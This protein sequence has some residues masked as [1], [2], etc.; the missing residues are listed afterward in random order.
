MRHV[1]EE[2]QAGGAGG[3]TP[4]EIAATPLGHALG[5]AGSQALAARLRR[6]TLDAGAVLF[7]QGDAGEQL[8]LVLAGR[9]LAT[10][11]GEGGAAQPL[12]EIGPGELVGES[13]L[14][15]GAPRSA[16]VQSLQACVLAALDAQAWGELRSSLPALEATIARSVAWRARASEARHFRPDAAWIGTW[17][18]RSALLAG[19][20]PAALA[21]LERELMWQV[22]PGGEQLVEEGEPGACMWFV[23]R[24]RFLATV[25]R[26]GGAVEAVGEIGPGECVG[27]MALLSDAPRSATVKALRD[28]ELLRLPKSAFDRLAGAHPQAMLRLARAVVARFQRTL[29]GRHLRPAERT[30]ALV[31]ARPDVPLAP[32]AATLS[33]ALSELVR[34]AVLDGT[35]QAREDAASAEA[36]PELVLLVCDAEATP[37]TTRCLRQAD[38][39]V[40]VARAGGDAGVSPLEQEALAAARRHEA[41]GH[42]VLLQEGGAAPRDTEAWLA[43][44]PGLR[45]HHVRPARADDHA[46]L[47]RRLSGRAVGVALSGGGA[48]G[49]AHIGALR[50]L[51]DAG[52]PVDM[53]AGT[54]MGAM[55]GAL[56][57]L[58]HDPQ[59]MLERCRAWTLARPWG[60]YTLPLASIV[61]GRRMRDALARLLGRPRIEDLWLPYACVTSNLTRACADAHTRGPLARLV[62]AS[63]A[64]PGLAPPVYHQGEV[65]V[66]GGVLDN[67]P[68]DVLRRMG[69]GTV[70]AIDVGTELNV[71]APAHFVDCPSGWALLWDGLRGR[72]KR[73]APVFVALTRAFTL[74]SDGR[75]RES[76]RQADL[77]IR[78][79]LDGWTSADFSRI[80]PISEAGFQATSDALAGWAQ[81]PFSADRTPSP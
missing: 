8:Y 20:E 31:P 5:A 49:F 79:A 41:T 12:G 30:V 32:F 9:L 14:L 76:A 43:Q 40:I 26:D 74:A 1:N 50:A 69:A 10:I 57:A 25:R 22:V 19:A 15:T 37:W 78:P 27:E 53:V 17:L 55:I 28:A 36:P 48:R 77:V 75:A 16:T 46:R 70:I 7:R 62:R 3:I 60:D 58:G 63:N 11:A 4:E 51:H 72:P 80:D 67:L 59:A 64:V 39:L 56:H 47:A 6:R 52:I 23:V 2:K 54:S 73:A 29:E 61:R 45:H 44:R 35:A 24:G 18:A 65:H 21:A 81:R 13:A 68:V 71:D 38:E 34:T 42:L 33:E 66:D